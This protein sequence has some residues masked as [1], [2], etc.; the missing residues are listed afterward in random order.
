MTPGRSRCRPRP[1]SG[2]SGASWLI[3]KSAS[4]WP[5][6][7]TSSSARSGTRCRP[8]SRTRSRPRRRLRRYCASSRPSRKAIRAASSTS[9]RR[10]RPS[11]R[12]GCSI[13]VAIGSHPLAAPGSSAYARLLRAPEARDVGLRIVA[14]SDAE[15]V[16]RAGL[17]SPSLELASLGSDRAARVRDLIA[18]A[19]GI[20]ASR[21]EVADDDRSRPPSRGL[22][23]HLR[24][25]AP[26]ATPSS[27]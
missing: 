18:A 2:S 12:P 20:D 24:R 17:V 22:E 19:A 25:L 5:G 9:R 26:A 6:R 10:S 3:R 15:P 16:R 27:P 11:T 13:R 4:C 1:S 8:G 21:V 7:S 23:I 14:P